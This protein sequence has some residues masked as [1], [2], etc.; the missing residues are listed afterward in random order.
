M[1]E[2]ETSTSGF[3]LHKSKSHTN[4]HQH[5]HKHNQ[6]SQPVDFIYEPH[7]TGSHST[8][9]NGRRCRRRSFQFGDSNLSPADFLCH[10]NSHPQFKCHMHWNE[11]RGQKQSAN[12]R[13]PIDPT[14]SSPPPTILHHEHDKER[15]HWNDHPGD[16]FDKNI[17]DVVLLDIEK[18]SIEPG[19]SGDALENEGGADFKDLTGFASHSLSLSSLKLHI[20]SRPQLSRLDEHLPSTPSSTPVLT[21]NRS[22]SIEC[23][24]SP[25]LE[26]RPSR[27]VVFHQTSVDI[28]KTGMFPWSDAA[29]SSNTRSHSHCNV[30][31]H[32]AKTSGS[33]SR[34]KN[35]NSQLRRLKTTLFSPSP[36]S[37]STAPFASPPSE[38][39]TPNSYFPPHLR[40]RLHFLATPGINQPM[41]PNS[42]PSSPP[43]S[44]TFLCSI[45]TPLNRT[46]ASR[47]AWSGD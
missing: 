19:A 25:G 7:G 21:P 8:G 41:T 3:K 43:P 18:S 34:Q 17:L 40:A 27:T 42:H 47:R 36:S 32:H 15:R 13:H 11:D 30:P 45:L 29:V 22:K 37:I 35:F 33:V 28:R 23:Q 46:A 44:R 14:M 38:Q 24:K 39:E 1:P 4:L 2:A 6:T 5:H 9:I 31:L 12:L 10:Q 16:F 20:A 26:K